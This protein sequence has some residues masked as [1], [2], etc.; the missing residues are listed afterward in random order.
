MLISMRSPLLN[1]LVS[2]SLRAEVAG[3]YIRWFRKDIRS[4]APLVGAQRL[5]AP[6]LH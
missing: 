4:P 3:S 2:A 1:P 6:L 5:L